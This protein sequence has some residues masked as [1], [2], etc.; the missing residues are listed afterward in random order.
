MPEITMSWTRRQF[1]LSSFVGLLPWSRLSAEQSGPW[2]GPAIVKKVYLAAA[3]AGWPRPDMDLN[4]EVAQIESNL[5]ELERRHPGELRLTG[6]EVLR[7][8]TDISG[9]LASAGDADVILA[10]NMTTGVVGM[11]R[12]VLEVGRPTLLFSLPYAGHEWSHQSAYG[13]TGMKADVLATSDFGELDPYVRLFRTV[14][15]LRNSKVLLV[16]PPASRPPGERY[17]KQFG[18]NFGYPSYLDLKAIYEAVDIGQASKAADEF[19]RAALRVVE[20]SRTEIVDSMRLDIAIQALLRQEKANAIAIDC[21][22]GF[23][24]RELPAYPCIAFAKLNDAGMYGVCECDLESTMTQLLVTSFSG[25]PGFVSDPVF[26]TSHNE[27]I[28]AHCVGAR[29]MRGVDGPS[30]PFIIRS[31]AEDHKGVSLQVLMP[32]GDP[33]TVARFTEPTKL[34]V[35]TGEVTRNVD[36]PRGCRTKIRT[37]VSDARKFL[38]T[39]AA[40]A[41]TGLAQAGTRDLLHRVVFYGDHT[42]ALERL[43]RLNGFQVI[44][45]V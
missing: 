9:W 34:L 20:P 21:L 16:S 15:H 23:G 18:T 19:T 41:K 17:Q 2:R 44:R 25:N 10:F 31:H 30:S 40:V 8:G 29:K 7:G 37:R 26:D 33:V 39:Y 22:G 32:V 35:S 38:D 43:A 1:A 45:E 4:Q 5:A 36:D 24:R 12:K 42:Q 27:V 13:Q 11:L 28:H 3:R 14:H 6:G